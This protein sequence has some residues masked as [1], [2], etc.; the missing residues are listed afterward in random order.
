MNVYDVCEDK[1]IPVTTLAEAYLLI[2]TLFAKSHPDNKL[3]T[4]NYKLSWYCLEDSD[5]I[6]DLL[7]EYNKYA[8]SQN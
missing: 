6:C 3:A 7:R 1:H 4:F 2:N 8:P 5:C